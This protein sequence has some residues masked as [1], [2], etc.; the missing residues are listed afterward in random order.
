VT[1]SAALARRICSS[2]S[3][4]GVIEPIDSVQGRRRDRPAEGAA[5]TKAHVIG[6]N[7]PDIGRVLG[8]GD[9]LGEVWMESCALR[10]MN[11]RKG[12]SGQGKVSCATA[13]G[14]KPKAARMVLG[15]MVVAP[16]HLVFISRGGLLKSHLVAHL[17]AGVPI[18]RPL[19]RS[20]MTRICRANA[21]SPIS[22]ILIPPAV[23]A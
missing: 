5:G 6:Q 15:F 7:G 12:C 11:P 9:F 17:C 20:I 14:A 22:G 3:E 8:R 2:S 10:L 13:G 18:G 23:L 16:F 21:L 1:P 19:M 4:L